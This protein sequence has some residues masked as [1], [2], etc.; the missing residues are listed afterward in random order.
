MQ[1]TRLVLS[2]VVLLGTDV[3]GN[4]VRNK[5]TEPALS[6]NS[7]SCQIDKQVYKEGQVVS[8]TL[9]AVIFCA[10]GQIKRI[11]F[12]DDKFGCPHIE[13]IRNDGKCINEA[14]DEIE[15]DVIISYTDCFVDTCVYG[16]AKRLKNLYC[17]PGKELLD[18]QKISEKYNLFKGA[19]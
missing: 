5:N 10:K 2:V 13:M 4:W 8:L 12:V 14:G 16:N 15:H 17:E 3:T 18:T 6:P 7:N 11:P 19:A 1:C 9:C